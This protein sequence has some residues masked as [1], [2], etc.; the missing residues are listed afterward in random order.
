MLGGNWEYFHF[1]IFIFS[2]MYK[3]THNFTKC[4][5]YAHVASFVFPHFLF[6]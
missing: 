4:I 2:L 1:S 3:M 6:V 5:K